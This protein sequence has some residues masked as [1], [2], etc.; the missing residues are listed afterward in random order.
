M[1]RWVLGFSPTALRRLVFAGVVVGLASC[2]GAP[3]RDIAELVVQDSTYLDPE[4]ATPYTGPVFKRFVDGEDI[5]VEAV[6]VDGTWEGELTIYH[7]TGRIRYQGEMSGGA[8]CGGW[9][10]NEATVAPESAYE[11]I[12]EDLESLVMYPACPEQ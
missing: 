10:E 9:V 1:S 7:T 4:T 12:K 6:L 5:Q 11:A 3:P 8:Q 2:T